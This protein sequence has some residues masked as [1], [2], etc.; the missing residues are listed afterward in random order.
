[1]KKLAAF[2][3]WIVLLA[4]SNAGVLRAQDTPKKVPDKVSFYKDIRPIFQSHCQGCHQP[5]KARGDYIM[6][7]FDKL[8]A[9]GDSGKKAIVPGHPDQ[10]YLL[11]TITP[12]KG[13]AN[14][15]EGRPALDPSDIEMVKRWIVQGAQ[16]DTPASA[17]RTYDMEHPPVY[18]HAPVI[19]SLD[20]SPDGKVLAVAAFHEVLLVEPDSG[21]LLGRLVGLSER[22]QAVRF[23]PDGARLAVSGGQ[24]G[25]M[26]E[27]QVWDVAKR[28]LKLS[29]PITFDTVFGVSWSPDGSKIAFG[30]TDN[31]LRAVDAQNG[32]Q[33]LFQGGHNDWVLDTFFT[34][35]GS[36]V[37]SASRDMSVKLTELATQRL[38][39]NVT[40][41]TPGALKGGVQALARHPKMNLFVA[42]GAD[43]M[44]R[45]Y[46]TVRETARMIGDDANL[47][48]DLFPLVGRVFS[49]RFSA[50]GKRIV[51][52][53][54]LDGKGEVMVCTYDHTEDVPAPIKAIM[55]KVPGTR[56]PAEKKA[57]ADYRDKGIRLLSRVPLDMSGVFAVAFRPDGNFVTTAGYD[58]M[59]R[60]F[61]AATGKLVKQFNPAPVQANQ[62]AHAKRPPLTFV[63]EK[64]EPETAPTGSAVASLD[65]EPKSISLSNAFAY[66]QVL[67][68]AKLANGDT[69]DVTR[70]SKIAPSAGIEVTGYGLIRPRQNGDSVVNIQ[71]QNQTAKIPVKVTGVEGDFTTD[72][73]RDVNPVL[74]R[75]GCNQGTC[76]GANKGKNGF[77]LSLRGVD[78]VFDVRAFLDDHAC[79][80]ANIASAED[81]LMLLKASGDVPHVG[82]QNTKPG[83][84]YYEL[85][86]SW[87]AQGAKLN[88][89]TTRAAKIEITPSNP[90]LQR[91]GEKQQFR[92]VATYDDGSS[93]DVTREAYIESGNLEVATAD[94]NG[95]LTTLRR[96]AVPVLARFD[97]AYTATTL[98]VMGDR[99]GFVWKDPPGYNR[100]DELTAA[101][102]KR[103]KIEPS[104]LCSDADFLRR[105][106]IDLTGV[107]PTSAQ[108]RAFLADSRES[109]AKRE[110]IV[111]TLLGSQEYLEHWSNKWADLLQVNRKFLGMEGANEFRK[112]IK[113]EVAQNTPYNVFVKKVL[114]ATGSNKDNP[115][116]S[117]FKILREAP[118]TMENTT[119]LFLG[120]RFN[121]N[122]CHDHPF[123]R[124]TQDQYYQIAAYFAQFELKTD[125]ASGGKMVGGTAVE[126]GKPLFEIVS[127]KPTGEVLHDRTG[128]ATSPKFPFTAGK[129]E[130]GAVKSTRR[131]LLSN[132]I[133]SPEN[134]YFAKSYVNRLWGYLFGVGIIEPLD[135]LRAGNPPSNAE[136]LDFLTQEFVRS[137][138]NVRHMHRLIVTSRTYQL[139]VATNKWNQDDRTNYS[140]AIARRLPAEV[141]YDSLQRVTGSTGKLPGGVRAA[142]LPDSGT[143][144]PDGFLS[145]FGRPPRD[146]ACECE[147]SSGM[148]FGPVMAM[149]NGKTVAD[150]IEDPSNELSK[151]VQQE[152]DDAKLVGE[153]FYRILNRPATANEIAV[154]IKTMQSLESDH[155]KLVTQLKKR[156]HDVLPLKAKQTE[157]RQQAITKAKVDLDTYEKAIAPKVAEAEKKKAERTSALEAQLRKYESSLPDQIAAWEKK[158][159]TTVPWTVLKPDAVKGPKDVKVTV[160]ADDS[161]SVTGK[162]GRDTYTFTVKSD[163]KGITALR[164]EAI[165]DP[166]LP[167]SGP[168]RAPDGNFVLTELQV[169]VH[170]AGSKDLPRKIDLVNPLA[171]FSQE[172]F[173]VRYAVDGDENSRDRGWAVSPAT[174]VSHW[175]TFHLKDVLANEAGT[176]FTI[177]LHSQFVTPGFTLGRFRIA[178]STA[179]QP[180][181]VSV[182]E[183]MKTILTTPADKRTAA[184]KETLTKYFQAIDPELRKRR[185]EVAE[186]RKPLPVD[187]RL[188]ELR[189][190]LADVSRPLAE[191][192][193]VVQLRQDVATS[194]AQ[195]SNRRLTAAQ[196]IS[197]AL[198][199]SPAFLFNH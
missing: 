96:G 194:A 101:K 189:D 4:A 124:W 56:N 32:E 85:I 78:A 8:L 120:V 103:M 39:D 58:G 197:W 42:G 87:I 13:K 6:T 75:M 10:S 104:G 26:G 128:L 195:L 175:A 158:Q 11:E 181:G 54:S 77:K 150:A 53:S 121:C 15:P 63:P 146:S 137:G 21:K 48:G 117:Y 183:E 50:D 115:A 79:R 74:S 71:F 29:V 62:V 139:S 68:T 88:S 20:Y 24:P 108:V 41:I 154:S 93:R 91:I 142:A 82:G 34:V 61:D 188:K 169:F 76:H 110:A 164:L 70:L 52:G 153:L 30:C 12:V 133:T 35:D 171:D 60:H 132:W 57:L 106:T 163:L 17:A 16:N 51:A 9:G 174:G 86:R 162:S 141:L 196:D 135:D 155:E 170:K 125:P 118:P 100:I 45:I 122:K 192:P 179:K 23:S 46:R 130:A 198:I 131:E 166:K 95:L 55:G 111:D 129:V 36:H 67:V 127:D 72:F 83:E 107:P 1:M 168:G 187:A 69:V 47:I 3:A 66:A 40:S 5:A 44:P 64:A 38:V 199:N 119:H 126:G 43:G 73:V 27:V 182:S 156:E 193:L 22:I 84:P 2:S 177:K 138:F 144:L 28:K 80:R 19:A 81:S 98:V 180:V 102:W 191:D 167:R 65:V 157:Q 149:V 97:G 159:N 186:S 173:D 94:R 134:P 151:L 25:R 113:N 143:D 33:V 92:V 161:V 145:T 147:R 140:H 184:Q 18:T 59:I 7:A 109:K 99:S 37:V 114:T 185:Q 112:W 160:E 172:N 49:V 90:L 136:L 123:E 176:V 148:Q 152:K 165:A 14:M 190:I 178:V 89:A 31:T 105:V 116:A